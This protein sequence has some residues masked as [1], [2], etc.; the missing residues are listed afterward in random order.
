MRTAKLLWIDSIGGL[1]AGA[2]TLLMNGWIAPFYGLSYKVLI[3]LAF[4]NL[5]YGTY[6]LS[7]AVAPHRRTMPRIGVLAF[8]NMGWGV[9]CLVAV[10]LVFVDARLLGKAHLIVEG[11]YVG[12]LGLVEWRMREQL[13]T[14]MDPSL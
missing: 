1:L 4:A 3:F 14:A 13:V 10:T 9:F 11:V 6:S 12:M 5:A 7:L 8:A 2:V